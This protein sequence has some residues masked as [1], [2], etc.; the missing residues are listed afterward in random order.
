MNRV[1]SAAGLQLMQTLMT[2]S[3]AK[4]VLTVIPV[5]FLVSKRVSKTFTK[6]ITMTGSPLI[7]IIGEPAC[8]ESYDYIKLNGV[9][10]RMSTSQKTYTKSTSEYKSLYRSREPFQKCTNNFWRNEHSP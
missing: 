7:Y 10:I 4:E 5:S 6:H 3:A 1:N 9:N 8:P 2:M